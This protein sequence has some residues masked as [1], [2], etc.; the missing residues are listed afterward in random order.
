[1]DFIRTNAQMDNWF[2]TDRGHLTRMSL[3]FTQ[4]AFKGTNTRMDYDGPH[5]DWARLRDGYRNAR[6]R[7]SICVM[8]MAASGEHVA[9]IIWEKCWM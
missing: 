8:N 6:T 2:L 5:Y 1:M 9:T 7:S 4:K 3:F